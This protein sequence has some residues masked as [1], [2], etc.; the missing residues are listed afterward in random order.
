[1]EAI[2]T[3]LSPFIVSWITGLTKKALPW[4]ANYVLLARVLCAFLSV[5]VAALSAWIFGTP[6]DSAVV[7]VL[8]SSLINFIGATGI[9]HLGND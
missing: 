5:V 4:S 1:M 8:I 6:F 3:A 7:G 2:A 9:F